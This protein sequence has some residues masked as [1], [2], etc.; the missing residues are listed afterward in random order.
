MKE[1]IEKLEKALNTPGI[2]EDE[3]AIYKAALKKLKDQEQPEPQPEPIKEPKAKA[4]RP[5]KQAETVKK[6]IKA[7]NKPKDQ[8]EKPKETR[9]KEQIEKE[10]NEAAEQAEKEIKSKFSTLT[11]GEVIL[12]GLKLNEKRNIYSQ[13]IDNRA[14]NKRRLSPTPEN[15]LRWIKNPGKFDLIGVDTFSRNDPTANYKK[16]ISKQKI[17]NLYGIKI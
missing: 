6:A 15:L 3:K 14:D 7:E 8:T 1:K 13:F 12:I 10:Y 16:T 17:F 5:K 4:A 11:E 9:S 2:S